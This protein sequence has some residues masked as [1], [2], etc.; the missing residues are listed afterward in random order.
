[1]SDYGNDLHHEFP[2]DGTT[3]A[4]LKRSSPHFRQLADTYHQ[5]D[6]EIHLIEA[7]LEPASDLRTE[8]LKKRRLVLLDEITAL[9]ASK[10]VPAC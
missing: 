10:K 6:K 8:E 3:I 1:M 2:E 7:S 4:D 9:I 5:L